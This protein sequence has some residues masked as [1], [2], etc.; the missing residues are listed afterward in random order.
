MKEEMLQ[1]IYAWRGPY[2][3][4]PKILG[5]CTSAFCL[6]IGKSSPLQIQQITSLDFFRIR[7]ILQILIGTSLHNWRQAAFFF[8]VY[9]FLPSSST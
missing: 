7:F 6:L 4:I 1:A 5:G 3:T 9:Q 8:L 2:S